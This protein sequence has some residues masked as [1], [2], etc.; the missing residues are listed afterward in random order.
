M[1]DSHEDT[2]VS[3]PCDNISKQLFEC[4]GSQDGGLHFYDVIRKD[5]FGEDVSANAY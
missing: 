5:S 2:S 4:D 1:I 3:L